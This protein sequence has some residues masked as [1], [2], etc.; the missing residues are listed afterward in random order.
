MQPFRDEVVDAALRGQRESID[1]T[2]PDAR[3]ARPAIGGRSPNLE[4]AFREEPHVLVEPLAQLVAADV[5]REVRL[6][7]VI[8]GAIE[9]CRSWP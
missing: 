1:H 5:L 7:R 3:V 8:D 9:V 4:F 6:E 2:A